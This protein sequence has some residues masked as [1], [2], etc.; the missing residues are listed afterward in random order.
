MPYRF[1][2]VLL[3]CFFD[4]FVIVIQFSE[5]I[6]RGF[7]MQ[8]L[9]SAVVNIKVNPNPGESI[10]KNSVVLV[11]HLLRRHSFL[12]GFHRNGRSVFIRTTYKNHVAPHQAKVTHENISRKVSSCQVTNM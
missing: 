4:E 9:G 12:S 7:V 8:L 5:E 10:A 2:V 3:G 1:V 11:N 6:L